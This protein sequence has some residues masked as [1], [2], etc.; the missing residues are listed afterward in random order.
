MRSS[1]GKIICD[2]YSKV[3][4]MFSS[5]VNSKHDAF[6]KREA[7]NEELYI[8]QIEHERI[9]RLKE[10]LKEKESEKSPTEQ[11]ALKKV[12]NEISGNPYYTDKTNKK[13]K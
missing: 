11:D 9:Q 3:K 13:D 12:Q 8:K 2:M 1:A 6:G 5:L 4:N 10:Q 7:A